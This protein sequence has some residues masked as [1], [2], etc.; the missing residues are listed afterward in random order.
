MT[1]AVDILRDSFTRIRD[2][3]SA[4][5]DGLDE[6]Q[7]SWRIDD[8]ANTVAWLIWHLTRVEDSTIASVS[9]AP[10]VWSAEGW[11]GRLGL[12]FDVASTGYG[13]T[14]DEVA[15]VTARAAGLRGYHDA[16]AART[17][18]YLGTLDS[19]ALDRVVDSRF[20]PPVTLAVRLVSILADEVQHA[21]QAAFLHGLIAR[22]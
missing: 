15:A 11:F 13:Q 7:L 18:S 9:G 2:L 3:V 4:S 8:E 6:H 17:S 21:G 12:P 20:D 1:T 5:V 10:E 16:V 14:S 19:S 22:A